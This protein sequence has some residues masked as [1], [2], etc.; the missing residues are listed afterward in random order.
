[1]PEVGKASDVMA[2]ML[3]NNHS[4]M[5]G[6]GSTQS[7]FVIHPREMRGMVCMTNTV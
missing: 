4:G 7:I 1:V 2:A 6:C 3:M 5:E